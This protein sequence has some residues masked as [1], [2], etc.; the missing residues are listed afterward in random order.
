[1]QVILYIPADGGILCFMTELTFCH[2]L[3]VLPHRLAQQFIPHYTTFICHDWRCQQPAAASGRATQNGYPS[4][5]LLSSEADRLRLSA[6]VSGH[7]LHTPESL[8]A[9]SAL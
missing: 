9:C 6:Q 2:R 5:P 3:G 7:P 1:M 4:Q 8:K